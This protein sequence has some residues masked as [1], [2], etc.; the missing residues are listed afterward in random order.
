MVLLFLFILTGLGIGVVS[1][2]AAFVLYFLLLLGFAFG[3]MPII[4]WK[5]K[6]SL[7]VVCIGFYT[8]I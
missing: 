5:G 8:H 7:A 4:G 6:I 3:L 1:M 2:F